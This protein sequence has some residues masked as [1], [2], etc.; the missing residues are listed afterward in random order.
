MNHSISE[1]AWHGQAAWALE[2][3]AL[4]TVIVPNMGAKIV[5]LFDKRSGQEWLVGAGER[6]FAPVPYT[7]D[8]VAQDMSGWDEMF[9]TITACDYPVPGKKQGVPLPDHGEVWPLPWTQ[10]PSKIGTLKFCVTGKALPYKLTRTLSY[11]ANDTLHMAYDLEN[12]GQE[13]MPY[14]WA[15]HPQ[16]VCGESAQIILPPEVKE[17]CNVLPPEWGWGELE[18]R[19]AWPK[20]AV[21]AGKQRQ[22]N[23]TEAASLKQIRKFFTLPDQPVSWAGVIRHQTND[24]LRFEWDANLVPYLGIWV[25]EGVFNASS[26]MAFEPMTGFYD[27]LELAWEKKMV[28]TIA[29]GETHTWSLAVRFGTDKDSFPANQ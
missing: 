13:A 11:S 16:F 6:P 26:V 5:S 12:L 15:A 20:T 22:S 27:S 24:W 25:D 17:V 4:R 18:A 9:P 2:N 29:A 14:I 19:Y 10:A 28:K 8:F 23:I 3:D 1:S 21:I 7:A